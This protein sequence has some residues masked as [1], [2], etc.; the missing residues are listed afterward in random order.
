MPVRLNL[1]IDLDLFS[2]HLLESMMYVRWKLMVKSSFWATM[3]NVNPIGRE[4]PDKKYKD[5]S[6]ATAQWLKTFR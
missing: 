2:D 3:S 6:S 1:V 5:V 4:F